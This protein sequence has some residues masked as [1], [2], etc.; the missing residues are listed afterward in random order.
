MPIQAKLLVQIF[1]QGKRYVAYTPLLD[2]STSG[3]TEKEAK[4]RFV[5]LLD[6]F[7]EELVEAGTVNEV[8]ASLGWQKVKSHWQPPQVVKN[9]SV[10]LSIPVTA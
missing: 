5:E 9:E 6:I 8:L 1:K 10:S 2:L 7:V 3:R 4:K